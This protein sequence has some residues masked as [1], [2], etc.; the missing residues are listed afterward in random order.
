[1]RFFAVYLKN[2]DQRWSWQLY[3]PAVSFKNTY[4]PRQLSIAMTL[5]FLKAMGNVTV[6]NFQ[7]LT[8]SIICTRSLAYLEP[9]ETSMMGLFCENI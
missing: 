5:K 9:S 2:F 8:L 3:R 4:F 7:S 6:I 1:M